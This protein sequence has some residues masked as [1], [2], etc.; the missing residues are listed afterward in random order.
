MLG[1][2]NYTVK[3][4]AG[5]KHL[6]ADGLSRHSCNTCKHCDKREEIKEKC[7]NSVRVLHAHT[8]SETEHTS[9]SVN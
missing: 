5:L 9:L 4:K 3:H 2:Y 1:T 6:N 7:Q 8:G